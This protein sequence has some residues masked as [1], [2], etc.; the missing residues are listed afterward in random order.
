MNGPASLVSMY[1]PIGSV[2]SASAGGGTSS[3]ARGAGRAVPFWKV[4]GPVAPLSVAGGGGVVAG[5]VFR[6]DRGA[7]APEFAAGGCSASPGAGVRDAGT[8]AKADPVQ[9]Q[10]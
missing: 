2:G 3:G 4:R 8:W 10:A 5:G 9:A 7:V 6:K 1:G